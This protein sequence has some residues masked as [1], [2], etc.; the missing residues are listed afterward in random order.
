MHLS[1]DKECLL[2]EY[3]KRRRNSKLGW[4]SYKRKRLSICQLDETIDYRQ[5][6][7]QLKETAHLSIGRNYRCVNRNR[8]PICQLEGNIGYHQSYD[9][10]E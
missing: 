9:T 3:I 4:K 10:T 8:L 6:E 5:L 2:S 1:T 7:G